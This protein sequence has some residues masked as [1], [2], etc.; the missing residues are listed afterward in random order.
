MES[1]T[2]E[3][4]SYSL[5]QSCIEAKSVMSIGDEIIFESCVQFYMLCRVSMG[6]KASTQCIVCDEMSLISIML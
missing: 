6:A 1:S 4:S 3:S 5:F 2:E